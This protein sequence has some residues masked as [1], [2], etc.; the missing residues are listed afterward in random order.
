MLI[1]TAGHI[2]HGKTALVKALTGVD[3]D[4][5]KEEK[6]RGITIDLGYAYTP[7]PDGD[8]LGFIDVPGHE[9]YVHNMLAGVCGIEHALLVVAADDG[10]MPQTRE[11]LEILELLGIRRAAVALTK[12]DRVVAARV[13]AVSADVEALLADTPLADSPLFPLSSVSGAGVD[14][15]RAHLEAL[16]AGGRARADDGDFRLAVDRSFTIAGSGTVV[17]GTVFSGRVRV[18]DK[19]IVSPAGREVRLRALHAQNRAAESATL[20]QR[21]ALNLA[22]VEKKE[23]R[24][25]DWVVA[26]AQHAPARRMD[27]RITLARSAA[28]A[29]RHW[30][31]VHLHLGA[32]DIPA[33][34]SL[35]QGTRLEPGDDGLAQLVLDRP[36]L[37]VRGDRFILRDQSGRYTLA[38]GTLLDPDA[39]AH[40]VR[41]PQR[42]ATLHALEQT[43]ARAALTALLAT[44]TSGVDLDGFARVANLRHATMTSWMPELPAFAIVHANGRR[45]GFGL[46]QWQALQS[47][48]L[49]ALAAEHLREPQRLGVEGRRLRRLATPQLSWEVYSAL[50]Q[51]LLAQQRLERHGPWLH[52]PGHRIRLAPAEERLWHT[53][54]PL[55]RATPFEPPWVRDIA[56][57]L[58]LPEIQVRSLLQRVTLLGDTY[59]VV[60]DRYFTR[61]AVTRLAQI[62]TQLAQEGAVQAAEFRNRIGTGRKLAIQILEYFDRTGFSR[63]V[64]DAHRMR[65]PALLVDKAKHPGVGAAHDVEIS[66]RD[67]HPG[68]AA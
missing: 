65:D 36:T 44:C 58:K 40:K 11:H 47:A 1:A 59:E 49:E 31:P 42:L 4:R 17:T 23:L 68:G 48:V 5:L 30:T 62:A 28:R 35:L 8:I 63:R 32:A 52:L 26:P 14:A 55:L 34:V 22:G 66:G 67:T 57:T 13:A 38:G 45:F 3:A 24:R 29:L 61:D 33:R 6:A 54:A 25:G 2:D 53:L 39:P 9:R 37:G 10:I 19:L 56:A 21:C 41:T 18:G 51:Q 20:G 16:A 60:H 12:I 46:P 50:I 27:A 15:L 64:G 43:P 7:L